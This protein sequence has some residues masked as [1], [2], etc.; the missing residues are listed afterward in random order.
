MTK[1]RWLSAGG[2][3]LLGRG[4]LCGAAFA[5]LMLGLT[6]AGTAETKP[7]AP[8]VSPSVPDS[9]P[10]SCG[11][12][13]PCRVPHGE[14]RIRM[15]K[16][17][18]GSSRPGA[19]LFL[20]GYR[21]T[22]ENE[23]NN[24]GLIAIASELGVA[25]IAPQ[26]EERSW[27]FPGAPRQQRDDLAFIR[28]I[29]DDA[30]ARHS[31]DPDKIMASGFSVGGSMVWYLACYIGDRFAGFAPVAGAFWEP[32]PTNC[33]GPEPNLFHV[34]GTSDTVVPMAGRAIGDSARQ[35]N[36]GEGFA[37]WETKGAC[38][39]EVPEEFK[40]EKLKL[41]CQRRTN[42]SG[43]ILELC[44]HPGGHVFKAAWVKRAWL[45]L[46]AKKGWDTPIG[47]E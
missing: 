33:P 11:V 29:L 30:I 28:S 37:L 40:P 3:K 38:R 7:G 10:A 43:R 35:G 20:H 9:L 27:S 2:V 44:L 4:F 34:H 15:P 47:V 45:E 46:A 6:P 5:A 8:F 13:T 21:G 23:I 17:W 41:V 22:A 16:G 1:A 14:Y 18:D 26:G 36:V 39:Q 19:I 31:V 25:L 12:D 32:Q 42:C 24:K